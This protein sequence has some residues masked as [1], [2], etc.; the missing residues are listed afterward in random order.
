MTTRRI[1]VLSAG[2]STPSSTRLLADRLAAAVTTALADRG[3]QAEVQVVSC[4][5]TPATSPT[6]WSPASRT[7]RWRRCWS[8]WP[9]RTRSSP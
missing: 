1:V 8:P 5:S 2:L 7:P 9:P 4:A 6:T 3:E